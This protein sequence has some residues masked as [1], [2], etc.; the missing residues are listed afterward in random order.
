[1]KF[2]YHAF[3][4]KSTKSTQEKEGKL[5]TLYPNVNITINK[6]S[7]N[8]KFKK[9]FHACPLSISL[10]EC[11]LL[12]GAHDTVFFVG[13][14]ASSNGF[15]FKFVLTLRFQYLICL[16]KR[17][18]MKSVSYFL[19]PQFQAKSQISSNIKFANL[20]TYIYKFPQKV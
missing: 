4:T 5:V 2:K 8:I 11:T 20:F 1:M 9:Q 18:K 17:K 12:S 10:L 15:F 19:V 3:I 7:N 13:Q 16:L 14:G 6:I